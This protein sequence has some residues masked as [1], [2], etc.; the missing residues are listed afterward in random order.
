L[1]TIEHSYLTILH[2]DFEGLEEQ[3]R[4]I[5]CLKMGKCQKIVKKHFINVCIVMFGNGYL[6][7]SS[8]KQLI[9]NRFIRS[10]WLGM[11]LFG[12]VLP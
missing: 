7:T 12:N 9:V 5:C 10:L 4:V 2:R 6:I 11:N 1:F 8:S 3:S